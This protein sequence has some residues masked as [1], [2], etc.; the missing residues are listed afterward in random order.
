[1]ANDEY[2]LNAIAQQRQC[3]SAS[4]V[5]G[6]LVTEEVV[7]EAGDKCIECGESDANWLC[8]PCGHLCVCVQ[9][10]FGMKHC[11]F[12]QQAVQ[13]GIKVEFEH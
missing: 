5:D 10:G 9:C 6:S 8:L 13:R 7:G 2:T 1:M 12:C 11:S 3:A 4:P